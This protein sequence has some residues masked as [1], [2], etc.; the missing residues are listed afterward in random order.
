MKITTIIE[1][2]VYQPKLVSEHGLS[3][4]IDTG[5]KR[6]LFDTGQSSA[7]HSNA[8]VLGI[9]LSAVDALVISHGHYD[10]TGGLNTFLKVNNTAPVYLK[11]EVLNKK[12]NNS[13]KFIGIPAIPEEFRHRLHFVE[14]M[15]EI[16][17]GI[18]IMPHIPIN[19]PV[20]TSFNYFFTDKGEGMV[21]DLFE[22]ELFM[23]ITNDN[24]LSVLSSCSHR[25]ITNILDEAQNRF[26]MPVHLVSGGFHLKNATAEHVYTVTEYLKQLNPDHIGICH[27]TGIENYPKMVI[28]NGNN[29]FYNYTGNIFKI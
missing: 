7:F 9:D 29:V 10:H 13:G 4:Y 21:N 11:K 26:K 22:D 18:Y 20:D 25:G 2:L 28:E 6:I 27:C 23:A 24:N 16:D 1:N 14:D 3:V 8:K 12:Y 17:D 19:Y 15:L 5:R